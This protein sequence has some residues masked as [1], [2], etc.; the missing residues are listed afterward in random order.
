MKPFE[1]PYVLK[2]IIPRVGESAHRFWLI[3]HYSKLTQ[4]TTG[5]HE[6]E[7]HPFHFIPFG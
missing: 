1:K 3:D 4:K 5:N 7:N 2:G 6:E